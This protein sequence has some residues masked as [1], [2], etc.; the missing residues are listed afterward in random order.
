MEVFHTNDI[1]YTCLEGDSHRIQNTA[2]IAGA[3]GAI[4]AIAA[5]SANPAGF[6]VLPL[7]AGAVFAKGVYN[8]YRAT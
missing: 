7:V 5:G 8:I 6:F 3:A 1:I 4:T 2:Y